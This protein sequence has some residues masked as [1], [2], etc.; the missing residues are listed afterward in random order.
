MLQALPGDW[1]TA[2]RHY[3]KLKESG[4]GSAAL[5]CEGYPLPAEGIR[6]FANRGPLA[7]T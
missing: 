4:I 7:E 5:H 2:E 6:E 3:R 1:R